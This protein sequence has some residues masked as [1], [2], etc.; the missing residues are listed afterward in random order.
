MVDAAA[1]NGGLNFRSLKPVFKKSTAKVRRG[2]KFVRLM[3]Q[4]DPGKQKEQ[5]LKC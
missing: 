2:V 3:I 5:N 1:F 4:D